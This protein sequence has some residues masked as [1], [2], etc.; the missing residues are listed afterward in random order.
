[1]L[2]AEQRFRNHPR[3][4]ANIG[5]SP[6]KANYNWTE[7]LLIVPTV[8]RNS[9]IKR[10]FDRL[11]H[12][13]IGDGCSGLV[14]V[15]GTSPQPT[16]FQSEQSGGGHGHLAASRGHDHR[17]RSRMPDDGVKRIRQHEIFRS[18]E[19]VAEVDDGVGALL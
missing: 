1:M 3:S 16:R 5:P 2:L 13:V 7:I 15:R 8:G 17:L 12:R 11:T 6:P 14:A 10:P 4:H 18:Q 19:I 9:T